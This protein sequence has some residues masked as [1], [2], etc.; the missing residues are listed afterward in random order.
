MRLRQ[1]C[2]GVVLLALAACTTVPRDGAIALASAGQQVSLGASATV[3]ALAETVGA[4]AELD[5]VSSAVSGQLVITMEDPDYAG[6]AISS[7]ELANL[8]QLR[9]RA[10]DGL[11]AA[12]R[13]ME[14]DARYD[15]PA[16]VGPAI[17][18]LASKTTAFAAAAGVPGA[19]AL[20]DIVGEVAKRGAMQVAAV[21][22]KQRLI[23]ASRDINAA[24]KL[25]TL[26]IGREAALYDSLSKVMAINRANFT[27]T[28]VEA[29]M[30]VPENQE[31]L[32]RQFIQAQGLRPAATMPDV[33]IKYAL[34]TLQG[35]QAWMASRAGQN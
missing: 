31:A 18:A 1:G 23:E 10:L 35:Y 12:Y 11:A 22:Q 28:L 4:S 13:A 34:P 33:A 30:V 32:L 8:I 21:K 5:L 2:A 19:N 25:L 27:G 6:A 14:D 24:N 29:G 7:A 15:Q 16:A 26:A 17:G 20:V 9:A 3:G